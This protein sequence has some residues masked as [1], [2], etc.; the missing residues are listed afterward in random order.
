[1]KRARRTLSLDD[2]TISLLLVVLVT[3]LLLC[4]GLVVDGGAKLAAV[5]QAD[6]L[7][8]EAARA[9]AQEL[10]IAGVQAGRVP[11]L[12]P[13][14]A[15]TAGRAVLEEAGARGAVRVQGT[16]VEATAEVVRPTVVLGLI[17]L[18]DVVGTGSA[19]VEL[20]IR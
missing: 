20:T 13:D 18:T 16:R 3:A 10:D 1:M 5:Q 2:G 7:A 12:L 14:R 11:A 4:L 9:A 6:Q 8:A 15:V 19:T 17:G